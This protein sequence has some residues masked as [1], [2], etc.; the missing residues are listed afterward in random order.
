MQL[1]S[2]GSDSH[3]S[4]SNMISFDLSG[5]SPG[6]GA[7]LPSSIDDH[8]YVEYSLDTLADFPSNVEEEERV[9]LSHYIII[10]LEIIPQ[11]TFLSLLTQICFLYIPSKL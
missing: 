3:A 2:R 9:R 8:E 11:D 5:G 7:H 6:T 1:E 10:F 4:S